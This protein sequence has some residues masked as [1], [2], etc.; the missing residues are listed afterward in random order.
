[1]NGNQ[2]YQKHVDAALQ[3]AD[4]DTATLAINSHRQNYTHLIIQIDRNSQDNPIIDA[5]TA[6]TTEKYYRNSNPD[7]QSVYCTGTGSVPCNCD[8]CLAGDDPTDWA[9][10]YEYSDVVNE[11]ILEGITEALEYN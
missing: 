10:D 6:E 3:L 11:E 8:G 5:W 9:G 2:H 1:M 7:I 4:T